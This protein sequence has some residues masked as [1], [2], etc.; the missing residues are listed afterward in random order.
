MPLE[1]EQCFT[2]LLLLKRPYDLPSN[3][4]Q[5]L[6]KCSPF[7]SMVQALQ[8][9]PALVKLSVGGAERTYCRISRVFDTDVFESLENIFKAFKLSGHSLHGSTSLLRASRV[10]VA[11]GEDRACHL[12]NGNDASGFSKTRHSFQI[13]V[14][15][16]SIVRLVSGC[17]HVRNEAATESSIL[18]YERL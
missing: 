3:L 1:F 6:A 15:E 2:H 12:E 14:L 5:T 9:G 17:S 8:E 18:H 16:D 10:I 7:Q 4:L 11:K 13:E